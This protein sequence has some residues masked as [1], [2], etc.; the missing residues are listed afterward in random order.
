M[1]AISSTLCE[2]AKDCTTW[3][4]MDM[5]GVGVPLADWVLGDMPKKVPTPPTW[6]PPAAFGQNVD[7]TTE[8]TAIEEDTSSG[9][10][11]FSYSDT[12]STDSTD[13]SGS[14]DDDNQTSLE[15]MQKSLLPSTATCDALEEGAMGATP[16]KTRHTQE[17]TSLNGA[18]MSPM[19]KSKKRTIHGVATI[20][21]PA[22]RAKTSKPLDGATT[23]TIMSHTSDNTTGLVA[24]GAK[25]SMAKKYLLRTKLAKS[26]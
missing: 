16:N 15:T 5:Q 18:T 24:T 9:T 6:Q 1:Q 21:G 7:T 3:Y 23:S 10:S 4:T 8:S 17:G 25:A 11:D 2:L 13:T 19:T 20:T 22:T 14:S 26:K 12:E